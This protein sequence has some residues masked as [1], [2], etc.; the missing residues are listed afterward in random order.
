MFISFRTDLGRGP[1]YHTNTKKYLGH[2]FPR[3]SICGILGWQFQF[4]F[5]RFSS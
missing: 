5:W 2:H 4:C 3:R 1:D